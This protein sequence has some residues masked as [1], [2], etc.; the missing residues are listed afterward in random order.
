M[1]NIK[2]M[3]KEYIVMEKKEL[4]NLLSDIR[5]YATM[6]KRNALEAEMHDVDFATR[7]NLDKIIAIS[8][9]TIHYTLESE[10]I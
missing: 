9:S 7:L 10:L 1:K 6:V 2:V 3:K 4:E 5:L 8:D